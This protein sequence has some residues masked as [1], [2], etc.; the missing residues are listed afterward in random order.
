MMITN[1]AAATG[2]RQDQTHAAEE[3][4]QT[5]E[6]QERS[7]QRHRP[8]KLLDRQDELHAAGEDED[9]RQQHLDD[10]QGV[11]HVTRTTSGDRADR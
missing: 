5:D 7:G 11:G 4:G 8:G 9:E 3:L 1:P 10:P 2:V 6:S